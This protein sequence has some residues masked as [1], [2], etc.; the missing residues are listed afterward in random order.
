MNA[1]EA[2]TPAEIIEALGITIDCLFIPP[3]HRA[4]SWGSGSDFLQW[5]V[6]ILRDGKPVY[7]TKY[8]AGRAHAPSYQA[9]NAVWLTEMVRKECET[10]KTKGIGKR[11]LPDVADVLSCLISDASAA[12]GSFEDFCSEMDSDP[13]SLKARETYDACA[14]TRAALL[15]AFGPSEW[16]FLVAI[17]QDY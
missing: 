7:V 12:E 10:G 9:G 8:S 3:M 1:S 17:F 13:D 5:S 2:T 6:A 11:I 14:K 15:R 4:D 16:P